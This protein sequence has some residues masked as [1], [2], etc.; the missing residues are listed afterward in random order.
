MLPAAAPGKRG[1]LPEEAA[2]PA[3]SHPLRLREASDR[4]AQEPAAR[5]AA[6]SGSLPPAARRAPEAT[7]PGKRAAA[8]H[9]L[10]PLSEDGLPPP[11]QFP[12]PQP[13]PVPPALTA[14][15]GGGTRSEAR[16]RWWRWW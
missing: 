5:P 3:R 11:A 1:Y 12:L 7:F 15:A 16:R 8:G 13:R 4:S 6:A 10:P 9:R 2:A 14:Y